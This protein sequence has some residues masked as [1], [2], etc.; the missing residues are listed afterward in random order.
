MNENEFDA[1]ALTHPPVHIETSENAVQHGDR[2][3]KGLYC[4][5]IDNKNG[6][7]RYDDV[8]DN[9]CGCK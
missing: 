4:I 9:T 7:F 8:V 1:F 5:N 6:N 2:S 3:Q